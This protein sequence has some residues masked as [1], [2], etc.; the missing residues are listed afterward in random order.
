MI[1][2]GV[3]SLRFELAG[4][5]F[6]Q[7][8]LHSNTFDRPAAIRVLLGEP[9]DFRDLGVAVVAL[10]RAIWIGAKTTAPRAIQRAEREVI[11]LLSGG[12]GSWARHRD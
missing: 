6:I 11:I 8:S 9:H 1:H 10:I 5:R 2:S 7:V 12:V 4:V 3:T